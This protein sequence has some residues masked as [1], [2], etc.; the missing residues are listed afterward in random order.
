MSHVVVC[1][2]D[3]P[4]SVVKCGR[5]IAGLLGRP[6]ADITR[7][8]H[9]ARGIIDLDTTDDEARALV[10]LLAEKSIVAVV[11]DGNS[12]PDL[13]PPKLLRNAD[14]GSEGFQI[15]AGDPGSPPMVT[16]DRVHIV[17][18]GCVTFDSKRRTGTTQEPKAGAGTRLFRMGAF[19]ITGIPISIR[20]RR[21]GP[22][23]KKERPTEETAWVLDLIVN[24]P[25]DRFRVI[26]NRFIYDYLGDQV[27][28][29][30]A[31]NFR[32][33]VIDI[34][35]FVPDAL[36]TNTTRSYLDNPRSPDHRFRTV[37]AFDAYI[38]WLAA[39]QSIWG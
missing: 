32:T 12:L 28:M 29:V 16:W 6:L 8:L 39:W 9:S 38:R 21:A 5:D 2:E 1:A 17:A 37:D 20:R 10:E 27:A 7:L 36:V 11:V 18:A 31:Q 13:A 33:L 23:P 24:D 4:L 15:Q 22:G 3:Q 26:S 25:T 30:S 19:A 35:G 14:P 34:I